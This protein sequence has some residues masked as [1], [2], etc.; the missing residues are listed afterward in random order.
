MGDLLPGTVSS[1][2]L[3]WGLS[4]AGDLG[5]VEPGQ[6]LP[7][8]GRRSG[9]RWE[10]L[11]SPPPPVAAVRERLPEPLPLVGQDPGAGPGLAPG[12]LEKRLVSRQA[13]AIK[14]TVFFRKKHHQSGF[15][16]GLRSQPIEH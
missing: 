8:P 16:P 4:Q 11:S 5:G 14:L 3:G 12:Q 9:R 15:C 6:G 2:K 7:G 1:F 10:A 13:G